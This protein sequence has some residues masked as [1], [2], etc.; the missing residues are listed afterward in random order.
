MGTS[1]GKP[2]YVDVLG[3][4][5][6]EVLGVAVSGNGWGGVAGVAGSIPSK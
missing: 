3:G 1:V 5:R 2:V 6:W 4:W